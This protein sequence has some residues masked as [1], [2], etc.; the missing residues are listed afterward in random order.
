MKSFL[1][2]IKRKN[3]EIKKLKRFIKLKKAS[4][5]KRVFI[6]IELVMKGS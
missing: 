4:E 1:R 5:V 6:K 3:K 2:R